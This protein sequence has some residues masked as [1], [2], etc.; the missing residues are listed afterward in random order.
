VV[1]VVLAQLKEQA[2]LAVVATALKPHQRFL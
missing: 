2:A 1:V